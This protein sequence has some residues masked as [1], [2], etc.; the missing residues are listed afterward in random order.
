MKDSQKD[1]I[2]GSEDAAGMESLEVDVTLKETGKTVNQNVDVI[3]RNQEPEA[4]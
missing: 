2:V 1:F 3:S 4:Q